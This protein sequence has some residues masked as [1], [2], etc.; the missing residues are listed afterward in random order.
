MMS[1]GRTSLILSLA[2]LIVL[3]HLHGFASVD[4]VAVPDWRT[5]SV[6]K[7]LFSDVGGE[8]TAAEQCGP[9]LS[10]ETPNCTLV[11]KHDG[12]ELRS[13]PAGQIW[14]QTVVEGSSFA[15]ATTIGFYRCFNFISGQNE[16]K[17]EIEMTGPVL[18]KPV[19]DVSGYS[20]SFFAPS[21]FSSPSDLPRPN[22]PLVEFVA[23]DETLHAVIGP[24]DG[25]PTDSDYRK[26][27]QQL[28][29]SL[30]DADIKYDEESVVYAGYSS[31]FEIFNR[32]QEVHV[33]VTDVKSSAG[34]RIR[35]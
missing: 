13:Y 17:E 33:V 18:I 9:K 20:I 8:E 10:I 25:F 1:A 11:E 32:Q 2:G 26:K 24:F 3:A 22:S 21:R 7:A 15:L 4:A 19:P 16:K 12:Y 5:S 14:V 31:P 34:W 28:K 35:W 27:W 6:L 30:D 29:N 23:T